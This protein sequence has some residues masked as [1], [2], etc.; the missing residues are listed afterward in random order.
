MVRPLFSF[1]GAHIERVLF[2]QDPKQ[3]DA[4]TEKSSLSSRADL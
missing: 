4:Y 2:I 1:D 3:L